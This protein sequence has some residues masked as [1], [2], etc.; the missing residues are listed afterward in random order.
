LSFFLAATSEV[1]FVII[2]IVV[3]V[4][5]GE[6]KNVDFDSFCSLLFGFYVG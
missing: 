2:G 3:A 1:P 6:P 5:V 4:P